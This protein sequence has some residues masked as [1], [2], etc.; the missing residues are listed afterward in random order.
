MSGSGSFLA[1]E[2]AIWYVVFL[3]SLT[4][5]EGAHALA[6]HLGGDDTAYRSGQVTL[7][8]IPHLKREPFGTLL[9]PLLSFLAAGWM[10]GWASTPFDPRWGR[11]HPGRQALMSLA[12]PAANFLIALVAFTALRLLLAGGLFEAPEKVNFSHL[13]SPAAGTPSSSLLVPLAL[14]L[15]VALNLNVLLGLF[16]LLPL[17]PLDGAGVAEG[18]FPDRFGALLGLLRS[19]PMF[20]ILSLLVAWKFFGLIASPAVRVV[21]RLVHPAVSY[22]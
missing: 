6:A 12:G 9:V 2:F 1:G 10:M 18:L 4:A 14:L 21:L 17:P 19:N 5:H 7:N 3:F 15:S 13:V 11:R 16:N 22:V 20:S 8:P